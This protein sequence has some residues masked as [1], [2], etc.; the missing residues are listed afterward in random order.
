MKNLSEHEKDL[1]SFFTTNF[2]TKT[3]SDYIRELDSFKKYMKKDLLAATP[4]DCRN[5]ISTL[6]RGTEE[7]PKKA[8]STVQRIY[9]QLYGFYNFLLKQQSIDSNPF[10]KVKKPAASK[11]V[12]VDRTPDFEDIKKLLYVLEEEFEFRDYLIVLIVATTG[13]RISEV[14]SIKWDS[15]VIDD[16]NHIAIRLG[17]DDNVRYVRILDKVWQLIDQYREDYLGVN[18]DYIKKSVYVFIRSKHVPEYKITPQYVP[19]LTADW[20]RRV[21]VSAR[22]KAGINKKI[23]AKDLRH[24]QVIYALKLGAT[25]EDIKEQL[26]WCHTNLVYRYRG[27]IEQIDTPA[28]IYTEKFFNNVID[29]TKENSDESDN[30]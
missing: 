13:L 15:F 4:E 22:K 10:M 24:A 8:S 11:Q 7:I 18:T 3:T 20:I 9:H 16:H 2:K 27:V 28:N 14:L 5:Y 19:P 12:N 26:G 6:K 1:I 30:L 23:T 29:T 21:L 25:V 17:K